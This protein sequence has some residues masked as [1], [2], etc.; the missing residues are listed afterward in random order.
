MASVDNNTLEASANLTLWLKMTSRDALTLADMPSII[1]MRWVYFRDNWHL[2]RQQLLN[3]AAGTNDPDYFRFA[4][5]DL[6]DFIDKQRTNNTDINPFAASSV[7]YRFLPVFENIRLDAITVT[8]DEQAL[9][10]KKQLELKL[11]SKGNFLDIKKTLREFRD[12]LADSI[13]LSDPDYDAIYSRAPVRQQGAPSNADLNLMQVI[14]NQLSAVDFILSNLFAVDTAI[15]PFALARQNANNPAID[16]RQYQS[17]KLV[18][19]NYGEDLPSLAKRY[20]GNPD[21]WVDI[22]IANG[23]KD[24]YVDEVG[25]ELFFLTNG[26]G[27]QINLAATDT[28]GNDNL[29]RFYVNQAIRIQSSLYPFPTQRLITGIKQIPL[30]GEIILTVSGDSNMSLYTL[31][32]NASIRIFKPN[33]VNSSQYVLIPSEQPLT[34]PRN[35]EIPWF[36]TGKATDEKNTKIDLAI[37]A[38]GK[39]LNNSNGDLALSYGLDNAVQAIMAKMLT[40]LGT[41]RRHPGF[42][43]INLVGTPSTQG[44]GVKV[45]L[46]KAINAQIAADSRFDRVQSLDVTKN[47]SSTGVAYDITLVVKLAGSNTNLP[48]TF[49]VNT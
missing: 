49:T 17:G 1:S 27:N 16:I 32:N 30:S 40:E 9:I 34:N 19:L 47:L 29:N 10:T 20:F 42:G 18:K 45:A 25:T 43:L 21:R 6:T 11:Y 14:Q 36:M 22:A 38:D 7:Y 35:E 37:D 28:S 12:S 31:T 15:D 4:L 39:L 23:L 2:L 48:I 13:G 41:N 5:D 3:L 46:V 33:T 8:N 24:P 26:S 44:D